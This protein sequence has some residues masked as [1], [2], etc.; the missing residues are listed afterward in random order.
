MDARREV[1]RNGMLLINH[2]MRAENMIIT[3]E[4]PPMTNA[5]LLHCEKAHHHCSHYNINMLYRELY[6]RYK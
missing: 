2:N 4:P 6:N 5:A 3:E 1:L